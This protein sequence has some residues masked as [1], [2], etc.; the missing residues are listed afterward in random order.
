[1]MVSVIENRAEIRGTVQ[2]IHADDS[3]PAQ[4]RIVVHVSDVR[5]VPGFANLLSSASGTPLEIS[6][7]APTRE[8]LSVGQP[9][10]LEVRRT[11]PTT[12]YGEIKQ[13]TGT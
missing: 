10:H 2:G 4:H 3:S 11:G 9:I 1:M 13:A 8:P 12:V 5:D 6:I 7:E